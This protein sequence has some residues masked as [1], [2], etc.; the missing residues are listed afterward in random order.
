MCLTG[1]TT[2]RPALVLLLA[3]CSFLSLS[4]IWEEISLHHP[5][6]ALIFGTTLVLFQSRSVLKI[7][8]AV[9]AGE[10]V[11]R[12]SVPSLLYTWPR[13]QPRLKE[14]SVLGFFS[15]SVEESSKSF[16]KSER[17]RKVNIN[18]S[19]FCPITFPHLSR[20]LSL[21]RLP[22]AQRVED[23]PLLTLAKV[24]ERPPGI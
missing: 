12:A 2:P 9:R 10:V 22:F 17:S 21:I 19:A 15:R 23:C 5:A 20:P 8:K 14:V 7:Q 6:Y 24:N 4:Y 11:Q 13:S 3:L 16:W 18:S 1:C